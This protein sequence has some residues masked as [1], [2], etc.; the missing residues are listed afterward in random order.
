MVGGQRGGPVGIQPGWGKGTLLVLPASLCH[1]AE[2]PLCDPAT[3]P[4][5]S[6]VPKELAWVGAEL[7]APHPGPTSCLATERHEAQTRGIGSRRLDFPGGG[8]PRAVAGW[9]LVG[10]ADQAAC[11]PPAEG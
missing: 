2:C 1:V 3:A 9:R 4:Q 8:H 7:A 6:R 10:V 5:P 11:T